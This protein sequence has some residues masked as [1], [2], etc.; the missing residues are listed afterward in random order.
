MSRGSLPSTENSRELQKPATN[1]RPFSF[2]KLATGAQFEKGACACFKLPITVVAISARLLVEPWI[3]LLG[4]N[5]SVPTLIRGNLAVKVSPR[6]FPC[7]MS[8]HLKSKE[9][10][11]GGKIWGDLRLCPGRR[12]TWRRLTSGSYSPQP[13][14]S[15]RFSGC[16]GLH[17]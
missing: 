16:N 15:A 14:A 9:L 6:K 12:E 17:R 10:L 3:S 11:L 2:G 8:K 1:G 4:R 5:H 13:T 7:M